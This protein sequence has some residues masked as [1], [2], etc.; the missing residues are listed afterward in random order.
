[1]LLLVVLLF[2]L[3]SPSYAYVDPGSGYLLWQILVAGLVG[4]LY[5]VKNWIRRLIRPSRN[6][7]DTSLRVETLKK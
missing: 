3:A 5:F 7:A 4:S 6:S 1:M 2:T